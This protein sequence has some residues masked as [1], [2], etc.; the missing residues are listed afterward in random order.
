MLPILSSRPD[1]PIAIRGDLMNQ[2]SDHTYSAQRQ[3]YVRREAPMWGDKAA[4]YGWRIEV[5]KLAVPLVLILGVLGIVINSFI[6]IVLALLL[7]LP[8][9]FAIMWNQRLK[10][11]ASTKALGVPV[12]WN[13]GPRRRGVE[14][15]LEWC[16]DQRITPFTA[17]ETF[18]PGEPPD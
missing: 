3:R 10:N 1:V 17:S 12:N 11:I 18:G 5:T 14:G 4:S 16:R 6:P 2:L 13:S 9:A 15:Y 7:A 8:A